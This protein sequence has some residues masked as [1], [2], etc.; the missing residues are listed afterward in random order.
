[1]RG[2]L[3]FIAFIYIRPSDCCKNPLKLVG[4][5]W[6]LF[7]TGE[8]DNSGKLEDLPLWHSKWL[9]SHVLST[10]HSALLCDVERTTNPASKTME[11]VIRSLGFKRRVTV[12]MP[13]LTIEREGLMLLLQ[14][15]LSVM[16]NN[17]PLHLT[18]DSFK[19]YEEKGEKSKPEKDKNIF[20]CSENFT[21]YF[22]LL[23]PVFSHV[24]E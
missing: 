1:M 2:N 13:H 5:V 20:R 19:K 24:Y 18:Q 6:A 8:N 10:I 16:E 3:Y 21:F 9:R 11:E 15:L 14:D 7:H 17:P 12:Q 23:S 22:S 4:H